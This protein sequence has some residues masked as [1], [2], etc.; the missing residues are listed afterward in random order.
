MSNKVRRVWAA[1]PRLNMTFRDSTNQ[2]HIVKSFAKSP[3]KKHGPKVLKI[4]NHFFSP[5]KFNT[6]YIVERSD[7]QD[8]VLLV[9]WT[10]LLLNPFLP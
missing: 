1:S 5:Y 6:V 8:S 10:D 2:F 3:I 4:V 7:V 9:A